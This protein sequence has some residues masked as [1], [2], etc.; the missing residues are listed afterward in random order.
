[1]M[2][3]Q[4]A[5]NTCQKGGQY[6]SHQLV[7]GGI[8]AGRFSGDLILPNGNHGPPV[9]GAAKGKHQKHRQDH[10]HTGIQEQRQLIGG[11]NTG[12]ALGAANEIQVVGHH[13]G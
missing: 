3:I 13:P 6:K 1:M 7:V 2:R 12:Q 9:T 10:Q 8:D 5:G 4:A 11:R